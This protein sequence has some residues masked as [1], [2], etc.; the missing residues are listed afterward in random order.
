[1][2]C[3][4]LKMVTFLLSQQSGYTEHPCF[5]CMWDSRAKEE[6]YTRKEWPFLELKVGEKNVNNEALAPRN[7]IIF[8][9]LHVRLELINSLSRL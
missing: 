1:M 5:L 6:H 8:P 3:V 7:K 2:I 9:P 4:G